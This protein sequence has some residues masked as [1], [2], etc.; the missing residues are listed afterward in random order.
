MSNQVCVDASV[1]I[2]WLLPEKTDLVAEAL[3]HEWNLMHTELVSS[4]LFN[5]EVT[6]SLR[7]QV[8]FKKILPEE[9]EIAFQL[10]LEMGI[11]TINH[12]SVTTMAWEMA[13]R[14][15]LPRTY[16]LQYLAVAELIDCPLWTND[17]KFINSLQNRV[18]RIKWVGDYGR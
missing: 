12:P 1:A 5:A 14:F 9:G 17:R 3:R 10:F 2:E 16:D 7:N 18:Q 11:R 15:N 4:P 8:Y 13:K 6:S